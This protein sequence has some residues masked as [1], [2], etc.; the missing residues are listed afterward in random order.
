MVSPWMKL[1]SWHTRELPS[2]NHPYSRITWARESRGI[3]LLLYL[4][5]N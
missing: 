3:G 1:Y 5:R 4:G 2:V